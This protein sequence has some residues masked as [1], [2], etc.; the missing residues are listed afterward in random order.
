[1]A[2]TIE[3]L[4]R[5]IASLRDALL[6]DRVD[7][8]D[9]KNPKT[10]VSE[11][12][13]YLVL[14]SPKI[15][16]EEWIK[17]Q[18]TAD[19]F[20]KIDDMHQELTKA[21]KTEWMEAAG[22]GSFAAS[23][24]KFH[25]GNAWWPVYLVS[26][27]LS[28]A[29]PAFLIALAMNLTAF[30]RTIQGGIFNLLSKIKPSL[31]GKILARPEGGGIIPR[32]Q[33]AADVRAR[34]NSV[35]SGLA[36]LPQNADFSGLRTQLEGINPLLATFNQHAPAFNKEFR[37]LPS[38]SK[39]TKAGLGVKAV[40]DAITGVNHEA[41]AP[42]ATGMGKITDAVK[43]SDPKKTS[44]FADAIGKLKTSMTGLEVDKVPTMATFQNA[45]NAAKE[46]A[47]HT[48]T[49]SGRMR[50]FATAVRD[51]NREMGG[52]GSAPAAA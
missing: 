27:F 23:L 35:L 1:M 8:S 43:L 5:E 17:T 47:Q 7:N 9:P 24:E 45:A 11:L 29:V 19:F 15:A 41:M 20:K 18:F 44:K 42:I 40:A 34:E 2:D 12:K 31:E 52:G 26:G 48:G 51:L 21:K 33:L 28:L 22:L 49:L 46:L 14:K 36:A 13:E 3:G 39:A 10:V 37:K 38:E 6:K 4:S 50:D 16:T 32:P 30:Q 25:E